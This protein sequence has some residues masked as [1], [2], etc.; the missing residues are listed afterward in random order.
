[1][2]ASK[3]TND[4]HHYTQILL[5]LDLCY[6]PLAHYY[7]ASVIRA[8]ERNA[9]TPIAV[10]GVESSFCLSLRNCSWI[11]VAGGQL[12]KPTEV[13]VLPMNNPFRRY[14]PCLDPAKTPS[15]NPQFLDLLGF[16]TQVLPMTMFEL[17]IK[18]SCNLDRD[19]LYQLINATD[20]SASIAYVHYID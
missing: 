8:R 2:I 20:N 12:L 10:Q 13:Y 6:K 5:Y 17:L 19:S 16:K 18:W 15:R 1:M 11:P 14:L 7:A 9:G 4:P 3:D